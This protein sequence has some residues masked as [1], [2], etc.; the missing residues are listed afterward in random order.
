MKSKSIPF[1]GKALFISVIG[2]Y[3][4]HLVLDFYLDDAALYAALSKEMVNSGDYI[5]L[6]FDGKD[7]LDKPHFSFWIT[8][9]FFKLF[10]ISSFSYF[11]PLTLSIFFSFVYTYA[12][13]KRYYSFEVAWLSVFILATSQY[14]IL[15]STEGRIEPYLTLCVVAC[16]YHFDKGVSNRKKRHLMLVSLFAAIAI[17]IKGIF[18]L[19]PIFGGIFGHLI[20]THRSLKFLWDWTWLWMGVWLLVFLLPEIYSLYVQF[21]SQPQKITFG[22]TNVSGIKWFLWDSQFSRLV[23][24]GPITRT[25]GDPF[26]YV[27]TLLWTFFPWCFVLYGSLFE[28]LK[29]CLT[30]AQLSEGYSLFGSLFVLLIFSISKFQLPH[31]TTIVFPLFSIMVADFIIHT[32][33]KWAN[34]LLS[35]S[36]LLAFVLSLGIVGFSLFKLAL[37]LSLYLSY[38]FIFL[39]TIWVFLSKRNKNFREIALGAVSVLLVNV[40]LGQYIIPEISNRGG[41]NAANFIN[42]ESAIKQVLVV[43]QGPKVSNEA[44]SFV[45][46]YLDKPFKKVRS[47]IQEDLLPYDYVLYYDN[48]EALEVLEKSNFESFQLFEHYPVE[49]INSALF[50]AKKKKN[51]IKKFVLYRR[52]K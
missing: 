37:P 15:S 11:L 21:D 35:G 41:L 52:K 38:G 50:D 34:F 47:L 20:Y 1:I 2:M 49:G 32:K 33:E 39:L 44:P 31:Y 19:I 51:F 36:I 14:M 26:F 43:G 7:W 48:P 24:S 18:I 13:A 22:K 28:R 27:H 3:C 16:I 6:I 12:F 5:S 45:N 4:Y 42:R 46:F 25:S 9:L 17:M 10:G 23:N 40:F 29:K 30:K 8:A